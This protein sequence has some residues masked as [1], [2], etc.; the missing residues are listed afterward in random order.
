MVS[1]DIARGYEV[2]LFQTYLDSMKCLSFWKPPIN[3]TFEG[4]IAFTWSVVK[5]VMGYG[6]DTR[7]QYILK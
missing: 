3:V 4:M 6:P 7:S 2:D 5:E 1:E